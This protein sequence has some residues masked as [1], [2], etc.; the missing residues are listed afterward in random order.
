MKDMNQNDTKLAQFT[1]FFEEVPLFG[2]KPQ[3]RLVRQS[4]KQ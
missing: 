2:K 3:T 1:L 4:K